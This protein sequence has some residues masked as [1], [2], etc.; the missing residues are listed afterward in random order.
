MFAE[1]RQ[2]KIYEKIQNC[3]AVTTTE[4]VSEFNVSIE[5]IRRDLLSM[6]QRGLIK[7]VHG[8]AVEVSGMK[9]FTSLKV[10]N[11]EFSEEKRMLSI[12]AAEFVNE[13]DIISID[14]GSTAMAFAQ[15][16]K[17]KFSKLTVVTHS[18]DVFNTL[19]YNKKFNVILCG[20]SFNREENAFYGS[21]AL[22]MLR[23][24]HVEKA[25][26]FPW[27][28][29]IEFG[30][31]DY[32]DDLLQIQKEMIKNADNVYVLS[33]SS[34]FEKKALLKLDDMKNDF[35]YITDNNLPVGL[36]KLYKEN[37]INIF[38][39]AKKKWIHFWL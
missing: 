2:N 15:I 20:G 27:A 34:K 30:I 31:C 36:E 38:K 9:Q 7:R 39:G 17:E 13:G 25:F 3:G 6:E 22:D 14:A 23:K 5:T 19:C 12:T 1:N 35:Y 37:N 11:E 24:T 33:D 26:I 16:L 32:Q 8:G 4:L 28:V 10:R 21:L 29:S 18:L